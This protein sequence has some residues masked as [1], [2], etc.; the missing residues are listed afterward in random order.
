MPR[1]EYRVLTL[2][3]TD[4]TQEHTAMLEMFGEPAFYQWTYEEQLLGGLGQQGWELVA[5][6]LE[7]PGQGTKYIFKRPLSD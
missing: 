4:Y 1:W 7:R 6:F 3:G 2:I 5:S